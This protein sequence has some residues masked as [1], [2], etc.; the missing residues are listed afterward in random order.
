M[1][2]GK[3]GKIL[4]NESFGVGT[5][6]TGVTIEAGDL[7]NYNANGNLVLATGTAG[8]RYAG[9][10]R[11]GAAE[12]K[13]C[14]FDYNE[15]FRYNNASAAQ[16]DIGKSVYIDASGDLT[17]SITPVYVGVVIDAKAG[18]CWFVDNT[19]KN[20]LYTGQAT[21]DASGQVGVTG[22]TVA[23]GK[24]LAIGAESS[25]TVC[26][27]VASDDLFT[28]YDESGSALASKLV[29]YLIISF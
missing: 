28:C 12:G 16:D 17:T 7:L 6:E 20:S 14:E 27:A 8:E 13:K 4:A 2:K 3:V 21:T 25:A 26:A 23:T 15:V 11:A 18:E 5:V 19:L 24:V 22:L 9:R 1:A 29:N 10:A